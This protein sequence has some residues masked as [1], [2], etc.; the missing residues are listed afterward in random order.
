MTI[1]N[2]YASNNSALNYMQ[3]KLTEVKVERDQ[4]TIRVGNLN[5]PFSVTDRKVDQKS[6]RVLMI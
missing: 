3:Y 5:T 2:V 1:L 4:F 6:E